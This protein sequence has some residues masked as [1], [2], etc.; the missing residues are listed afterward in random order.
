MEGKVVFISPDLGL[1][2]SSL[3]GKVQNHKTTKYK[4]A[5]FPDIYDCLQGQLSEEICVA[6]A[7]NNLTSL[8]ITIQ[9]PG[10]GG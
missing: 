6:T 4:R 3:C 8:N 9:I 10:G 1:L 2:T 7:G 5:N